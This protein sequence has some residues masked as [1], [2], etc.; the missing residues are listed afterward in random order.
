M[1]TTYII[2]ILII[3]AVL[4]G[5]VGVQALAKRFARK[6]PEFGPPQDHTSSCGF[7]CLCKNRDSC[8]KNQ[9][10]KPQS[11]NPSDHSDF[12]NHS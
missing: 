3:L 6:H 5:W 12:S 1:I 9:L 10:T 2:T 11:E 7:F 8:T 4:S